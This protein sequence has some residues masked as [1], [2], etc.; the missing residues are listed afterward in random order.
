MNSAPERITNAREF[1]SVARL[2]NDFT[3]KGN[4]HRFRAWAYGAATAGF[5]AF[6]V[7]GLTFQPDHGNYSNAGQV[8]SLVAA[9]ATGSATAVNLDKKDN[10]LAFARELRDRIS[11]YHQRRYE[12]RV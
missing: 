11:D 10:Y 3:N 1:K 4:A 8:V 6:T 7:V 12:G 9:L 5:S 2:E